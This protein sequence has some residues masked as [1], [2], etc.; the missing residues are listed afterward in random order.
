MIFK[1]LDSGEVID[2]G[3]P[4]ETVQNYNVIKPYLCCYCGTIIV[5]EI[6]FPCKNPNIKY[7]LANC[8]KFKTR[9]D[10]RGK[11]I[12]SIIYDSVSHIHKSC[13]EERDK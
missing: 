10:S 4:E 3:N 8:E 6:I 2:V 5:S 9:L 12:Y 11:P 1:D 13:L 7:T